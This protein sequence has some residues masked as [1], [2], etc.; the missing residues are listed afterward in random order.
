MTQLNLAALGRAT[1]DTTLTADDANGIAAEFRSAGVRIWGVSGTFNAIGPHMAARRQSTEAC[2]HV[3]EHAPMLGAQVVTLCT[4]TR[5]PDDMWRG[6]P[7]N[8]TPRA[9]SDLRD[10]LDLLIPHAAGAGVRLGIEPET[11]NV[12][13]DAQT[14]VRLLA[15]L[16]DDA[17]H[18]A[19]VLDPANLLTV[20][21]LDRQNDILTE[22]FDLLGEQTAAIH[23]KDVVD[24]GYAAPGVGSMDYDLVMRLYR[25]LPRPVPI[26]A[27]DLTADD[28]GRVHT[29]L[30]EHAEP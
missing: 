1:L 30:S 7:D 22:A 18:L 25:A 5:D 9:W 11:G 23:A 6:H 3:I 2:I 26:I 8:A 10:T 13:R 27:Q 24:A 19:I 14:A 21:T 16:G 4:G 12:V 15:Q 28:A 20:E 29:F 17:R